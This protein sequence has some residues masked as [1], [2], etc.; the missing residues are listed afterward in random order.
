VKE[1]FITENTLRCGLMSRTDGKPEYR[2]NWSW[3]SGWSP[4][5]AQ[6]KLTGLS[7]KLL[8]VLIVV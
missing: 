4:A 2:L 5:W 8:T 3:I 1:D 7:L 6:R